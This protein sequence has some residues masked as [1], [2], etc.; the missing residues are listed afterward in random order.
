MFVLFTFHNR[1]YINDT[2]FATRDT[3]E[4]HPNSSVHNWKVARYQRKEEESHVEIAPSTNIG[5]GMLGRGVFDNTSCVFSKD[6][7]IC[8][9]S[10]RSMC[11]HVNRGDEVNESVPSVFI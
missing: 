11:L 6:L 10:S 4:S 7:K 1:P 2:L 8:T 5:T 3:F 9:N